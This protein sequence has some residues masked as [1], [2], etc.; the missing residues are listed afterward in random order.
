V[1]VHTDQTLDQ[2]WDEHKRRA[3]ARRKI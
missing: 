2:L 1:G 3:M